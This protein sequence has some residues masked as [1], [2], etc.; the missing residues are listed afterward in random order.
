MS[1]TSNLPQFQRYVWESLPVRREVIGREM[2]DDAVLVAVQHWPT[3]SLSECDHNSK[4][5]LVLMSDLATDISRILTVVYGDD[6]YRAVWLLGLRSLIYQTL[7]V[8]T[9]WWRRR[10]DNRAKMTTWRRKWVIE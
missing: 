3:E 1:G 4:E 7:A 10:K 2:V 8:I 5:E 6:R 9:D